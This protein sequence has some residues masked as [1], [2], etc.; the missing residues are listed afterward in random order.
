MNWQKE[1]PSRGGCEQKKICVAHIR[2]LR[3][4]EIK[5]LSQDSKKGR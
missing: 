2:G 5:N 1:L 3:G 4:A